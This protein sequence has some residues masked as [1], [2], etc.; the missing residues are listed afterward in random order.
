MCWVMF[1]DDERFPSDSFI[2]SYDVVRIARS[3]KEAIEMIL[4][5]GCPRYI[6]FDHDLGDDD[7][8]MV[9]VNFLISQDLDASGA[10]IPDDFD[11]Y[12]HSQNPIGSRNIRNTIERYLQFRKE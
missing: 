10:F 9:L 6:S 7:T 11:F 5:Y 2:D 4:A 8:S 3:S 12:V 1:I